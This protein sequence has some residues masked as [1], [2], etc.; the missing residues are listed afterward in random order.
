MGRLRHYLKS[1]E[2][3]TRGKEIR[4]VQTDGTI[5]RFSQEDL[6]DAFLR[7]CDR[8]RGEDV[9][10]HP[11]SIAIQNAAKREQWHDSFFDMVDVTEDLEDLSEP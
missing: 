8:L 5:A 11:L 6:K 1:L 10:P 9:P 3:Q 4:I 2:R 7:N